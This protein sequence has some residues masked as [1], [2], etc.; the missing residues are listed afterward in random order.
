MPADRLVLDASVVLKWYLREEGSDQALALLG[1][2]R[3][4]VAPDFLLDE[5]R[6]VLIRNVSSRLSQSDLLLALADLEAAFSEIIPNTSL[7]D[8]ALDIARQLSHAYYDC[9]YLALALRLDAPLITADDK[10]LGKIAGSAY[11]ERAYRLD[12]LP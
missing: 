1:S 8:T 7:R 9:L 12:R 2:G 6:A 11:R 4:F 5:V 10:F 3:A